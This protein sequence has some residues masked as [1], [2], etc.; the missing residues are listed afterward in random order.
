MLPEAPRALGH[1]GVA[2][3]VALELSF[4]GFFSLL[5]ESLRTQRNLTS[6]QSHTGLL[7]RSCELPHSHWIKQVSWWRSYSWNMRFDHVPS[8]LSV[9]SS[10]RLVPL[11]FQPSAFYFRVI[12]GR[13]AREQCEA[14]DCTFRDHLRDCEAFLAGSPVLCIFLQMAS[15]LLYG[16]V[17]LYCACVPHFLFVR[18]WRTAKLMP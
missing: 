1:R 17:K 16:W 18:S 5:S 3:G 12:W 8:S 2:T 6:C 10:L 9:S 15:F 7:K 11:P 4:L 13:Q 14:K